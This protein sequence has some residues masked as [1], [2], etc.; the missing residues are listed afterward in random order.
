MDQ[1]LKTFEKYVGE[2]MTTENLIRSLELIAAPIYDEETYENMRLYG[3][4]LPMAEEDPYTQEQRYLHYLWEVIDLVPIG[5]NCRFSI[6]YRRM[7]AEKL[8]KK[9]GTGF[10]A[11]PNCRFNYGHRIEVGDF[12]AW[13]TG[14]YV[15]SKGTVSFGD[16]TILAE[17]VKIFSHSHSEDNHM[18]RIYKPVHI[19]KNVSIFSNA[20]ILYGVNIG[21]GAHIGV[22]SIVNKDVEANILVAGSPAKFIRT[23]SD[24]NPDPLKT[25]HFFFKK[26][27]FQKDMPKDK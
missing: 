10:V 5:I 15:D 24:D 18:E 26:R 23:L 17:D 14:I 20:T 21:D 2:G 8:F 6:Q 11:S 7:I 27:A 12:V 19:G 1:R 25:N 4:Y 16:N 9:C 13:N 22:N 3:D